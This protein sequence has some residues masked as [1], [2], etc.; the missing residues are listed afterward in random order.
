MNKNQ[1]NKIIT[2]LQNYV[3]DKIDKLPVSYEEKLLITVPKESIDKSKA[4]AATNKSPYIIQIPKDNGIEYTEGIFNNTDLI[5]EYNGKK[6]I[7]CQLSM[8]EN[9]IHCGISSENNNFGFI[10]TKDN[11][12]NIELAIYKLDTTNITDIKLSMRKDDINI[13]DLTI[14]NSISI[15]RVGDIGINSSAIGNQVEASGECSHAEGSN[16][17]AQGENSHAEGNYTIATGENSHAEGSNTTASGENSHAEGSNTIASGE[18]SHAEGCETTASVYYSHAEGAYT[19]ASGNKSH[20]EGYSTTA[21]G[22]NSHAE[23]NSTTAS[24]INT[25]TEGIWTKAS[26]ANQHVQGRYNIEDTIGQYAHIVGNG[27]NLNKRSNA[28][29][30]DWNGNAWYAGQVEGTNLP[31]N[32]SSKV[33]ATIPASNVKLGNSITVNNVSIN[34]DRRYYIEFLGSKKLCSLLINEDSGNCIICSIGNYVIQANNE[35]PDIVIYIT[36]L[37]QSDEP[38]GNSLDDDQIATY[39]LNPE[40]AI[41]PNA[42]DLIIHEEEIK[43]LNSKYLETDLVLQNSISLGRVGNIGAGSSAV[44]YKVEASGVT[45]HAEG[46]ETNASGVTSHAEGRMTTASGD[47]SHAEG[48]DT[49]ALG[50]YSHAEGNTTTASGD[51]SHAEGSDT[52]ASGVYSHAEGNTTTA[53]SNMSHAEGNYTTASGLSSHAEGHMTTASG[54]YQHV[55]GKYNIEDTEGK[56]AHI[57]GNGTSDIAKSNA[58]TL[59]WKGNA[60]YAGDVQ[61]NNVPY[62]VGEKVVL[63]VPAA[64]ITENKSNIISPAVM[65]N[66]PQIT[67]SGTVTYDPTKIYCLKYNNKEYSVIYDNSKFHTIAD[68]CNCEIR[69][70][71]GSSVLTIRTLDTTNV[72]DMQLIE[73]DVRKLDNIYVPNDLKVNNSISVGIRY[74][75]IGKYSSSFGNCKAPGDYSHAEGL[76]TTASGIYSHAEGNRTEASSKCSHAEGNGTIANANYSHAEGSFTAATGECSHAEGNSTNAKGKYSHAEGLYAAAS[77]EIAHAEGYNTTASSKHQHVQGKF[78]IDDTANKYAHIV[79]NGSS[80]DNKSNAHTLDWNG[81]GW[82]AGKLSQEGTPTEDKDL[83]TKKYVDEKFEN[84][85]L[86]PYSIQYNN[87]NNRLEFI[88]TPPAT[89]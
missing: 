22:E 89:E 34:K 36:K 69:T 47:G 3:D 87:E 66:S 12:T 85:N 82:Y 29:T 35:S 41:I 17:T 73:K 53:S 46:S 45:S 14:D 68:D 4:D 13:N 15:G 55:Q 74:G 72:T 2:N 64:S 6:Y 28:H 10:I 11:S 26:S 39:D 58:H 9:Q 57:V 27:E 50:D 43:Y 19:R 65:D 24:G 52:I 20:A 30:L 86:G 62:V 48:S 61:A 23:G 75:D 67:V 80:A 16:T 40:D 25:H 81:N 1:L 18:N 77:G 37:S 56:Y 42:T 44:G 5:I 83:V 31:Y 32:I 51:S 21:S 70:E 33:L 60:W 84:I 63:T 88:Y 59:D 78:N 49:I 76:Q 79:G 54:Q 38:T 71:N 7:C 8:S